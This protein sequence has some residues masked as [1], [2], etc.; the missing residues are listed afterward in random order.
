MAKPRIHPSV[1]LLSLLSLCIM[2][3]SGGSLQSAPAAPSS[4]ALSEPAPTPSFAAPSSSLPVPTSA[5]ASQFAHAISETVFPNL[6]PAH[7]SNDV[8]NTEDPPSA[9]PS[10]SLSVGSASVNLTAGSMTSVPVTVADLS[11]G[12]TVVVSATNLPSGVTALPLTFTSSGTQA[13]ILNSSASS[14]A[15]VSTAS[16]N[17]TLTVGSDSQSLPVTITLLPIGEP[18][19]TNPAQSLFTM[20]V[21]AVQPL[22]VGGQITVTV[23]PVSGYVGNIAVSF[24]GLLPQGLALSLTNDC[25]AGSTACFYSGSARQQFN[26]FPGQPYTLTVLNAPGSQVAPATYQVQVI[27]Q[28]YTSQGWISDS[29]TISITVPQQHQPVN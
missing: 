14:T 6:S 28:T 12:S 10:Y 7:F 13:L 9:P 11:S 25:P 24:T 3:C 21:N 2:G 27:A 22:T 8:V 23:T 19:T 26:T 5:P 15:G 29:A 18:P 4:P 20:T 16:L 17:A 1:F